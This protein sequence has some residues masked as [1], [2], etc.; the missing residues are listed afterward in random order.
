MEDNGDLQQ[1]VL[2][3]PRHQNRE[4]FLLSDSEATMS[5]FRRILVAGAT[6]EILFWPPQKN[7]FL[8]FLK[9]TFNVLLLLNTLLSILRAKLLHENPDAQS[10]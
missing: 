3:Q 9:A 10:P 4:Y 7:P 5:C 6:S 2:G 1:K 8:P